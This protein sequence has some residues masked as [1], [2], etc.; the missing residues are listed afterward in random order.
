MDL[1]RAGLRDPEVGGLVNWIRGL[2]GLGNG[3]LGTRGG[4]VQGYRDCEIFDN[5]LKTFDVLKK[6]L[7]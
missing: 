5:G 6:S 1:G 4:G 3:A 7:I 2:E